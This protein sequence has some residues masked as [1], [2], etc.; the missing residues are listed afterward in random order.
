M[1]PLP[2]RTYPPGYKFNI[3]ELNFPVEDLTF[4]GLISLIDPPRETVPGAVAKCHHAGIK[5]SSLAARGVCF[6][7]CCFVGVRLTRSVVPTN[8][9][10]W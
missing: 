9:L 5:A 8:R 6:C 10:S 4:V 1:L 7:A 3:D 2:V